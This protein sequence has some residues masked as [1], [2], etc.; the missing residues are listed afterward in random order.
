MRTIDFSGVTPQR[1]AIGVN[2]K[3]GNASIKKQ[4][5]STVIKYDTLKLDGT[6]N[7]RFFDQSSQRNFP[8]SN[9][10]TDGN[11]LGVG[12]S[13]VVER[14]YLTICQLDK[15]GALVKLAPLTL[16]STT[17][18]DNIL[19]GEFSF[20]IANATVIKQLPILSWLPEFNKV[21][22]NSLNTNY[23][24]D[25]QIVIPPLLEYVATLRLP[26]YP[27]DPEETYYL[28]LTIEGA[29]AIIAP[30]ATF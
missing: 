26:Q 28:R 12:N 15:N 4:Q 20:E 17:L 25:T 29:G 22:E 24:F 18:V 10:G 23:E 19:N 27:V 11:K 7:L 14:A 5:G 2:D 8:L 1:K 13:M 16:G 9:T 6:T 3:F 21:A 30:K